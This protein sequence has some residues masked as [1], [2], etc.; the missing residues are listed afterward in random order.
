MPH[1]I[2]R[3]LPNQIP[4][5]PGCPAPATSSSEPCRTYSCHE[6][7]SQN[8]WW[9]SEHSMAC[10]DAARL[11][12]PAQLLL[13]VASREPSSESTS[14]DVPLCDGAEPYSMMRF[15]GA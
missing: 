5:T 9:G 1:A 10:P 6:E 13:R 2:L 15:S 3:L 8:G 4:G 11:A 7:G 14:G 12:A